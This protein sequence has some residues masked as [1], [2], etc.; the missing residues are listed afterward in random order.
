MVQQACEFTSVTL[1]NTP[2]KTNSTVKLIVTLKEFTHARWTEL[3]HAE[4]AQ[5]THNELSGVE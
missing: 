4:M 2:T 1:V 3:T 5:Y